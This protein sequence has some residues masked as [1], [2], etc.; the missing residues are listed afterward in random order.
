MPSSLDQ[1]WCTLVTANHILDCFSLVTGYGHI[2]AR[3]PLTNTTF[4]FD[5]VD[6]PSLITSSAGYLEWNIS[7]VA[8]IVNG[9][10]SLSPSSEI[11]IHQAIYKRYP[12]INSVV[13]SHSRA[14][15]PFADTNIPL[16]PQ[17]NLEA[18]LGQQVPVFDIADYY[19]PNESHSFLVN[20][21]HLGAALADTFSTPENN[22]TR[23]NNLPDYPVVLQRAHGL[24][25][26]ATS[27]E[28]AVWAAWSAQDAA[29]IASNS[30]TVLG[31][32]Q[33]SA[34][35]LTNFTEQ[36]LRDSMALGHSGE[37]KDWP[38]FVDQVRRKGGY[39]N[40]AC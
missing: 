35:R 21:P 9:S 26:A 27:I 22:A 39:S 2:S 18:V 16:V 14:V 29:N 3:N 15:L 6:P 20:L 38:W 30:L 12:S 1:L 17:F 19:A 7:N 37:V 33:G 11:W 23:R 8:Y 24:S 10:V 4:F 13:H 5:P 28:H 34:A 36:E 25:A 31:A 40:D 32:Y